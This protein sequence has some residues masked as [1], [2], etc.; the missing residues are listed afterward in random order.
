MGTAQCVCGGDDWAYVYVAQAEPAAAAEDQAPQ[1]AAAKKKKVKKHD[2]T[3]TATGVAALSTA[4]IEKFKTIEF[5]MAAQVLPSL[6]CCTFCRCI[7]CL[8]RY[9]RAS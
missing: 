6:P 5:E 9:H 2:L 7:M 8:S 4:Q 1:P 3:L